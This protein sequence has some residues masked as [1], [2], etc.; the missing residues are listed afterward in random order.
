MSEGRPQEKGRGG[1]GRGGWAMCVY[2]GWKLKV[3]CGLIM[4]R[5]LAL[6]PGA[7]QMLVLKNPRSGP[8]GK[9]GEIEYL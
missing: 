3:V 7:S 4:R 6:S 2:V 5:K 9:S 1:E 8:G